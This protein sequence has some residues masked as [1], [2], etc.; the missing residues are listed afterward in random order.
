LIV[1]NKVFI[2]NFHA[3]TEKKR[4][5]KKES[6]QKKK[7]GS[8]QIGKTSKR[9]TTQGNHPVSQLRLVGHNK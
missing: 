7:I 1:V 2:K 4:N 9:I 5:G 8:R 3:R 6:K